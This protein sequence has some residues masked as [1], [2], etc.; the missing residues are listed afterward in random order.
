M[1]SVISGHA[2]ISSHHQGMLH[3]SVKIRKNL[4]RVFHFI[5]STEEYV[6]RE[7]NMIYLKQQIHNF[8]AVIFISIRFLIYPSMSLIYLE[9]DWI[10]H[11]SAFSYCVHETLSCTFLGCNC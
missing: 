11:C 3:G 1:M 7:F 4:N 9:R 6:S 2:L 8:Y 10:Y 5:S